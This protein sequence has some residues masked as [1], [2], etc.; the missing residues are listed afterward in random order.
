[1]KLK[2]FSMLAEKSEEWYKCGYGGSELSIIL[3][4]NRKWLSTRLKICYPA[5]QFFWKLTSD[6]VVSL[7]THSQILRISRLKLKQP[8]VSL[9]QGLW[10]T[11]ICWWTFCL[12]EPLGDRPLLRRPK[13][14]LISLNLAKL[15]FY[16]P[17]VQSPLCNP[18]MVAIVHWLT[19][20]SWK[21]TAA[22]NKSN[23]EAFFLLRC[24]L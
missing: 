13:F 12:W 17:R 24:N 10:K 19:K 3:V 23:I 15:S 8:W 11:Y 2:Q 4:W 1:M 20:A 18:S 9:K 6:K 5:A 14:S 21:R 7:I 22:C 16:C